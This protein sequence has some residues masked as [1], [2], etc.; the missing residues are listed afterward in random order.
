MN[1]DNDKKFCCEKCNFNCKY[2]SQWKKH[3]ETEL[4]IKGIKK[5]RSDFKGLYK[6]ENCS[7]ETKNII[8]F[9]QHKLN[10][11][12]DKKTREK[13]FTHYCKCCDF[14]TFSIQIFN[15]HIDTNKHKTYI[16]K[17]TKN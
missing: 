15:K 16:T 1:Q 3:I 4:H 10:E 5:K 7:Y 8:M 9:K 2:E 17:T 12:S 11:H 13:D 14:G 6:C